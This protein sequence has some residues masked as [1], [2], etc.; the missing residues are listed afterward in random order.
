M[1]DPRAA[2]DALR[3]HMAQALVAQDRLVERLLIGL[4]A[5]G[6]VLLEGAPG[7]AKTRAVKRLAAAH[8]SFLLNINR[9]GGANMKRGPGKGNGLEAL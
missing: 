6:H 4:L 3:A 8:L 2:V 5:G 1:I 9:A 7:L